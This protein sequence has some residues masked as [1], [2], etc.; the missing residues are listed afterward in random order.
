M[1]YRIRY[2]HIL[3]LFKKKH[4]QKQ[5]TYKLSYISPR[6]FLKKLCTELIFFIANHFYTEWVLNH[7]Q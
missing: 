3:I 4:P 5:Y 7:K 1:E 2:M 6:W